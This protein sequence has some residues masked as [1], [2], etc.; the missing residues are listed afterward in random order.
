MESQSVL[1]RVQLFVV[2]PY[3]CEIPLCRCVP[4]W[5]TDVVLSLGSSAAADGIDGATVLPAVPVSAVPV[6]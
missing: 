4:L 6:V 5:F 1:L 3:V 2:Q